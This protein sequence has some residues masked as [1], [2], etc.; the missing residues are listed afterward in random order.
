[1]IGAQTLAPGKIVT[2]SNTEVFKIFPEIVKLE[3]AAADVILYHPFGGPATGV[4]NPG[5]TII[6]VRFAPKFLIW[7]DEVIPPNS[8]EI[9]VIADP[10]HNSWRDGPPVVRFNIGASPTKISMKGVNIDSHWTPL[11]KLIV[12]LL[13][14]VVDVKTP[15][16]YDDKFA[17]LIVVYVIL[18]LE[19]D[20]W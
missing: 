14:Y 17:P 5:P 19:L 15:G 4:T 3:L 13:K 2:T 11:S 12:L 1:M 8:Y 16:S 18:S 10:E 6:G 9:V 7:T 20:H